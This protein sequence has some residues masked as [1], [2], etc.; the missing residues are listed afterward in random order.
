MVDARA[1]DRRSGWSSDSTPPINRIW[2]SQRRRDGIRLDDL[3]T[4]ERLLDLAITV[5]SLRFDGNAEVILMLKK[6]SSKCLNLN[7]S[8]DHF[9]YV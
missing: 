2:A 3:T 1:N 8:D 4:F 7:L 9:S 6:R 5:F